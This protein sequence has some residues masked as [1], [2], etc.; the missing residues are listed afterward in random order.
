MALSGANAG[1]V[2]P[3]SNTEKWSWCAALRRVKNCAN[4]TL[5]NLYHVHTM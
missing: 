5:D 4:P 2:V 3:N 1:K